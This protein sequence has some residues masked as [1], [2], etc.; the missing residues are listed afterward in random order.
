MLIS[1]GM[2]NI[3]IYI[4]MSFLFQIGDQNFKN[5]V[6]TLHISYKNSCRRGV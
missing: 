1:V 3:L 6:Q 4:N 5:L 2:M